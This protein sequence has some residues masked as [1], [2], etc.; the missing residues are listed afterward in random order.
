MKKIPFHSAN[1]D[2]FLYIL[3]LFIVFLFQT[4]PIQESEL[5]QPSQLA[6]TSP[7]RK[8]RSAFPRI[9]NLKSLPSFILLAGIGNT[10]HQTFC[11]PS[12]GYASNLQPR[13]SFVDVK[14]EDVKEN[15]L[16]VLK[17]QLHDDASAEVIADTIIFA[18]LRNNNQ[19][20]VKVIA[21]ALKPHPAA[22]GMRTIYETPVSCQID[23]GQQ[24]GMVVVNHC[25][26]IAIKKAKISGVCVV[27]VSNY[28]SAT[29]A[30]GVWA[31]NISRNGLISIVMSQCPEMVAP[32]GSY[33]PIFGT[34]P[35]AIGIPTLPRVQVLD[36][37]TSA[38]AWYGLVTAAE[39]GKSIPDDVAYDS[40]GVPTTDP[41]EAMKGALRVFDR[42]HKGSHLALMV[43]L[44]AG[45]LTGASMSD[46]HST[47]NW[48][49]LI[50]AID[51]TILGPI[52]GFQERAAEMC[53]RV[54]NAK[55]LP[56][57]EHKEI[58]LPGERGDILEEEQLRKGYIRISEKLYSDLV[59]MASQCAVT[60]K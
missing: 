52:E 7:M 30:L 14:V 27:G 8:M 22:T 4:I 31:R 13:S 55:K 49:S 50:I 11:S 54:K 58:F 33:E 51:P 41:I 60:D 44:L 53:N 1:F 5:L 21:G 12:S 36:M 59:V 32:C 3:F 39:E 43:E 46:K 34:N 57:H 23:G 45:A 56:G 24:I 6:C 35:L 10:R 19:G 38:S 15:L 48:G 47:K 18:E 28:S 2:D 9:L 26:N 29:G 17:H 25:V 20:I 16:H 42:G 40:N 37:A